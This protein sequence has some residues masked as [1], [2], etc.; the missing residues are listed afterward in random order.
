VLNQLLNCNECSDNSGTCRNVCG[1]SEEEASYNCADSGKICCKAKSATTGG[2]GSNMTVWIV[3]LSILIVLV[4]LGII[5]RNKLR[6]WWYKF[7]GKAKT[8]KITP[9][10]PPGAA[11]RLMP[12]PMP[13]FGR[14]PVF[15]GKPITRAIPVQ[16]TRGSEKDKELEETMSKLKKMSE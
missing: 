14:R 4:I 6:I 16:R 7:R 2:T 10:A 9:G 1:D 13:M 15:T 8:S 3:I 12:R 11:G 5:F